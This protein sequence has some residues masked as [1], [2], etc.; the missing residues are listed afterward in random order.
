[1]PEL[2]KPP[3]TLVDREKR[4]AELVKLLD[5]VNSREW[6]IE[7]YT[8][9]LDIKDTQ[10]QVC[11][12]LK[13]LKDVCPNLNPGVCYDGEHCE[14][15]PVAAVKEKKKMYMAISKYWGFVVTS[16][17]VSLLSAVVGYFIR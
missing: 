11:V 12:F 13:K 14:S 10:D 3:M 9:V 7:M 1:M 2:P 15:A 8:D 5:K 16:V 6:F 17:V 4:K